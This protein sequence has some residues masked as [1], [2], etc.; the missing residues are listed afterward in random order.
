MEFWEVTVV[1]LSHYEMPSCL[2]DVNPSGSDYEQ[3]PT[4]IVGDAKLGGYY[5]PINRRN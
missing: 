5:T 3:L 4:Y 1:L 2:L